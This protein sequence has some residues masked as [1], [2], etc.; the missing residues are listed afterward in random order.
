MRGVRK[1]ASVQR[2]YSTLKALIAEAV[3]FI[4]PGNKDYPNRQIAELQK[5]FHRI[6]S[7]MLSSL[8]S[9]ALIK[10]CCLISTFLG[11]NDAGLHQQ[12]RAS[13]IRHRSQ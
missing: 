5:M 1:K 11:E 13:Q 6:A 10:M 2:Y 4:W 9:T 7:K 3:A 12:G 8:E